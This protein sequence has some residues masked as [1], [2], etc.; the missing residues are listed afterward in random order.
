MRAELKQYGI[1]GGVASSI[2]KHGN[3][4]GSDAPAAGHA[5]GGW[6]AKARHAVGGWIGRRG[7]VSGDVVP[8]AP[9]AL[10]A[11]GEY[12]AHGPGGQ[13]AILNR[14]QAPI[15]EQALAAGGYPGLDHLPSGRQLPVLERALAPMGGL[16]RLF[17]RSRAR[18][19]WRR[20]GRFGLQPAAS[21]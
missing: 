19:T 11:Y 12:D 13:R 16:D 8:I 5:K 21:I 20:A 6:V 10:A 2:I 3:I 9:G 4:K 17:Q 7:M 14:H 1:T 15:A 18:T